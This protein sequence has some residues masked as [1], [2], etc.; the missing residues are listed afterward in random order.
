MAQGLHSASFTLPG[1]GGTPWKAHACVLCACGVHVLLGLCSYPTDDT[2]GAEPR[3]AA[4]VSKVNSYQKKFFFY[5]NS[6]QTHRY[7]G[8]EVQIPKTLVRSTFLVSVC[9]R[10]V[11]A[12]PSRRHYLLSLHSCARWMK[13]WSDMQ[14][15]S[16]ASLQPAKS[17]RSCSQKMVRLWCQ[18]CVTVR[19]PQRGVDSH[20]LFVC[21]TMDRSLLR[22]RAVPSHAAVCVR[23]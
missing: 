19:H 3:V 18:R 22:R 20:L 2:P 13:T 16:L 5:D 9:L 23:C 14:W 21:V 10:L 4:C 7:A 11:C 17:V 12:R 8:K 6:S 1:L 15:P